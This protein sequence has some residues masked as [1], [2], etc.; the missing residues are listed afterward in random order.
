MKG[1]GKAECFRLPK[2]EILMS[3]EFVT[4]G[5]GVRIAYDV[6]GER[7]NSR[8]GGMSPGDAW[9]AEYRSG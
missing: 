3:T 9:L 4:T 2:G 1:R 5:D 8:L 6:I 7:A